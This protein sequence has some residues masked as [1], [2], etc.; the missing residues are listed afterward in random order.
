MVQVQRAPAYM[1]AGQSKFRAFSSVALKML[2]TIRLL[3]PLNA[4]E[5][6][7]S[8]CHA[9]TRSK[10]SNGPHKAV[11]TLDQRPPNLV[12]AMLSERHLLEKGNGTGGPVLQDCFP[13]VQG[14]SRKGLQTG[15]SRHKHLRSSNC[16]STCTR[17]QKT[18]EPATNF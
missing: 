1:M 6:R 8:I 3:M 9:S 13:L 14:Q 5:Q 7:V 11:H 17:L 16:C 18:E 12:G 15:T 10:V 2:L 4:C